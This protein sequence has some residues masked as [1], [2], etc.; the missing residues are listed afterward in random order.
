MENLGK[1]AARI[2]RGVVEDGS[3]NQTHDNIRSIR[4]AESG[5]I[6]PHPLIRTNDTSLD[7][8]EDGN[9]IRRLLWHVLRFAHLSGLMELIQRSLAFRM[10]PL[11]FVH[12]FK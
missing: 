7:L 6:A 3:N 1:E 4:G 10:V 12:F 11:V 9:R 2:F 5:F 8:H